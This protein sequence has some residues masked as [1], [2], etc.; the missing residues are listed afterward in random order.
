MKYSSSTPRSVSP[1][2]LAVEKRPG[3]VSEKALTTASRDLAGGRLTI[4]ERMEHGMILKILP[5]A[6]KVD[7]HRDTHLVQNTRG[8][9][10]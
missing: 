2:R 1:V 8:T 7:L 6:G 4:I 5:N 10:A 9:D 3:S